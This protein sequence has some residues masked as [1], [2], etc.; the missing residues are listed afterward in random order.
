MLIIA[1]DLLSEL[2]S[3]YYPL[4]HRFNIDVRKKAFK[5]WDHSRFVKKG[6]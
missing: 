1:G 4:Q 2:K 3:E 6:V 5:I